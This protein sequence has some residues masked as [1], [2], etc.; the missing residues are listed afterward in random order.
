MRPGKGHA[1]DD[2]KD[3]DL[4]EKG[5]GPN[6]EALTLDRRLFMQLVAFGDVT[7]PAPLVDTLA[8]NEVPATL[9]ADL[10]DP[11]GVALVVRNED[12]EYFVTALRGLLTRPPF[13]SLT[14]RPDYTMFGR[15]Y[16]I[17]YEPDLEE[18][19]IKRPT[20]KLTDSSNAWAIWYPLRRNGAFEQLSPEEQ[21]GV[22]MEHG[23]IGHAYG[24]AGHGTDIRLACH[25]LDRNDNDFVVGLIGPKLH[26]L[27]AIV[28]RMRKTKQTSQY[29]TNLGPFFIG[30]ALWQDRP[31]LEAESSEHE[32]AR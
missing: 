28:Q 15:T 14:P 30:K 31:T 1:P 7:D 5:R 32:H 4:S 29:L 26:P 11:R 13:A 2:L 3:L 9:Y 17:G 16:S 18:A 23:A 19:L 8:S 22:L 21:R 20:R 10:N 6:G 12:P 27:S 25:G 24:R